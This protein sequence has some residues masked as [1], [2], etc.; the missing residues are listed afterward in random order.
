MAY[1]LVFAQAVADTEC[2]TYVWI[3]YA[4]QVREKNGSL[5]QRYYIRNSGDIWPDCAHCPDFQA[6]YR[7]NG[8]P[9]PKKH[10]YRFDRFSPKAGYYRTSITCDN[11]ELYLDINFRTNARIELYIAGT[12]GRKKFLA[13]IAHPLFGKAPSG[14]TRTQWPVAGLPADLPRLCLQPSRHNFYMQTGQTY[15]FSYTGKGTAVKSMSILENHKRL[16]DVAM[17]PSGVFAYTPPHDPQLDRV[18][19]YDV[20]ETVALVEEATSDWDYATTHTLLLH[21]SFFA[22]LRLLPGLVL[23]GVT[24]MV[25]AVIVGYKRKNRND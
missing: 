5:T 21:R 24:I 2:P 17:S 20:K 19:P 10:P 16:A 4:E 13:Q 18:G 25:F 11:G 8:R 23:F 7:L 3:D 6:F 1:G 22:H 9:S 14:E 15:Q 12:C